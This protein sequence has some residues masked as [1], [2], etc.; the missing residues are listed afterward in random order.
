MVAPEG[1]VVGVDMSPSMLER[2]KHAA[3][4]AGIVNV[5]FRQG[6]GEELPVDEG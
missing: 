4:E 3:E 1:Q 2:A 6:Y 5:D